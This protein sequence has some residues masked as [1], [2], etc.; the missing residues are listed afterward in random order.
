MDA[1]ERLIGDV[2]KGDSTLFA[3][4]DS[5]ELAWQ[6][7]DAILGMN[8]PVHEYEPSSWGP[9]EADAMIAETGGWHCPKQ[10]D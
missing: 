3:R 6:I 4:Q 9:P 8:T 1:Y 10:E 5:V 2:V 7:V